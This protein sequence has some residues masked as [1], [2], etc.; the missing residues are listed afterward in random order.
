MENIT[1]KEIKQYLSENNG[2]DEIF[3]LFSFIEDR[4][5]KDF[6]V[7][8]IDFTYFIF[9]ILK[10]DW[11]LFYKALSSN[12]T[13]MSLDNIVNAYSAAINPRVLSVIKPGRV[14]KY[15]EDVMN[16]LNKAVDEKNARNSEYLSSL[17]ILFAILHLDV[18]DADG[19]V[20]DA[21]TVDEPNQARKIF[22]HAGLTYNMLFDKVKNF[23]ESD[24]DSDSSND[25]LI[26]S[27][28]GPGGVKIM[29]F[30]DAASA[31][32]FI[33]SISKGNQ[34]QDVVQQIAGLGQKKKKKESNIETYCVNLN[35]LVQ[36]GKINKL[37]GRTNE[38]NEI[39]RVLGR[40]KKNNVVLVGDEGVGKTA[41]AEGL[42]YR[43][44]HKDVPMFLQNKE[45]IALNMTAII[46]GTTLRGM[47]EERVN[48]LFSEIRKSGKYIL[49]IDDIGNVIGDKNK[50]EDDFATMLSKELESGDVQVIA[51]SNFKAYR[52]SFDK[53]P[54]LARRFTKI[55]VEAPSVK[56]AIE[57]ISE[58]KAPYEEFHSVKFPDDVV[59]ACV[60]LSST[61]IT[62]RNLPDSAIDIID[63]A[64]SQFSTIVDDLDLISKRD[65][66]QELTSEVE[67]LKSID[68]YKQSDEVSKELNKV[69]L[70]YNKSK[71][72]LKKYKAEHPVEI[73]IDNILDIVS[74]KTGIPVSQMNSDD[75]KKLSSLNDRLKEEIIGQDEQIDL[76]CKAIKRNR[77]GLRKSGCL[78]SALFIAKTGVGKTLTAKKLAKEMFGSEDS[79]IR[80][81]MSEYPDKSAVSKLIG[82]NPGYVGYEDGGQLTE[83]VKN[84]KYCVLLLDE[85][86]KAD[87]EVY[88]IFLQVLDEGFLTD[89]SGCRVDFGNVIVLFTSNVGAKKASAFGGGI[90]FNTDADKNAK[91]I[92]TKELKNQFPPEF[93]NRLDNI[94]YFNA[95]TKENLKDIIRIELNKL[96][97]NVSEIGYKYEYTD[98][99]V[100]FIY[101]KVS[102]ELEY[103][104]RPIRRAIQ[105]NIEDKITDEILENETL[106]R[107]HVFNL[108]S[109]Y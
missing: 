22:N 14:I 67:R 106:E 88:N 81:D 61:Y 93:L 99:T 84:K 3:Q 54:S 43:I 82:S 7:P 18:A 105:E 55:I 52:S 98:K 95:L 94:I 2:S 6:P 83:A 20:C 97:K 42:A 37:V 56:E 19:I 100:D 89:N 41:I 35:D 31:Q 9:S 107:G 101:D 48:D 76:I 11:S 72:H 16:I 86:E 73:T 87:K 27:Q 47:F 38:F 12:I 32:K 8:V 92:M 68:D 57:I 80:F 77:V 21:K 1:Y 51:T 85:I 30:K 23:D 108:E 78:Y 75:K 53:D 58:A 90:G 34:P 5:I 104:A 62:E 46:A 69:I 79:L 103:G 96:V 102:E 39:I 29:K 44:V 33:D 45:V 24:D 36:Q 65:K 109:Q 13:S 49:L 63:E 15:S 4:M 17:D 59:K 64:G 70:E 10:A 25:G 91:S 40:K 26:D 71:E 50:N 60:K 66:I 74:S 28:S